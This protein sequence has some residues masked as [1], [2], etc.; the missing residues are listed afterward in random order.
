MTSR[1]DRHHSNSTQLQSRSSKNE[2]LYEQLYTN[3]VYTEFSNVSNNVVD[4]NDLQNNGSLNRREQYHKSRILSG[5]DDTLKKNKM[6]YFSKKQ[7]ENIE[8]NYNINDVLDE[9]RK[10]RKIEDEEEK[11]RHLK[12]IE[13]SILSD[14]S[15]E[16]L[17]EY[18]DKKKQLSR[19]E[20]EN[21]EELI[22]TITSNS[23]R[24]RIDDELLGDLLPSEE[25]ETV[26]LKQMLE[27]ID[28]NDDV[29]TSTNNVSNNDDTDMDNTNDLKIDNSFY[30]RSME[31]SKDDFE[32]DDEDMSFLE[33]KKMGIVPKILIAVAILI[34]IGIIGY[35]V[36]RFI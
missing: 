12:N 33:E 18:K 14:L 23:L 32:L 15:Q 16:K 5:E 25:S 34:V 24:K 29:N 26:V 28:E 2:K 13:Y 6:D 8:K 30:T 4:L 27:S 21:L 31:L 36:Y 9:A 3:K 22:H 1:M 11:Q 19:Q 20:E 17:K 7:E 10:N 35:V